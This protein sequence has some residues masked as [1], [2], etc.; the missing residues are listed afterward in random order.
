MPFHLNWIKDYVILDDITSRLVDVWRELLTHT[1]GLWHYR[2][3]RQYIVV[4]NGLQTLDL[5]WSPDDISG[6]RYK[7]WNSLRWMG[8][9]AHFCPK[10]N[11]NNNNKIPLWHFAI[12][13][14]LSEND[15][16][17]KLIGWEVW[18]MLHALELEAR[19]CTIF[20]STNHSRSFELQTRSVKSTYVRVR[21]S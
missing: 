11:S 13:L 16:K 18:P 2:G 6:R 8:G 14:D 20:A 21:T 12:V 7:M 9:G 17:D 1:D 19:L 3:R 10:I 4:A 15:W 5:I